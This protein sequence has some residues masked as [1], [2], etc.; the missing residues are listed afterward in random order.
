M[1]RDWM[2]TSEDLRELVSGNADDEA[3][4]MLKVGDC[5]S[6]FTLTSSRDL[7]PTP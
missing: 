1:L 6:N 2:L 3:D 7:F 5:Q 4:F